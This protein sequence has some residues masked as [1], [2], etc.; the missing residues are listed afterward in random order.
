[1]TQ[2][3]LRA[4]VAEGKRKRDAESESQ[5]ARQTKKQCLTDLF[6]NC[7]LTEDWTLIVGGC[8]YE[9]P[10]KVVIKGVTCVQEK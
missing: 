1:M 4:N 7:T 9:P 2:E 3:M 5:D 6:Y 8:L 10:T